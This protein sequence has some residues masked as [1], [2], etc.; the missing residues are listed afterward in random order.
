[1]RPVLIIQYNIFGDNALTDERLRDVSFSTC[2]LVGWPCM[3]TSSPKTER[4]EGELLSRAV[5]PR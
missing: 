3:G 5:S 4:R 1:T 2:F